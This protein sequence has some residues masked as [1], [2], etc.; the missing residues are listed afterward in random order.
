MKLAEPVPGS[1]VSPFALVHRLFE[2]GF[3]DRMAGSPGGRDPDRHWLSGKVDH[4]LIAL[5]VFS[6]QL[7]GVQPVRRLERSIKVVNGRHGRPGDVRRSMVTLWSCVGGSRVIERVP[8]AAGEAAA[9]NS[10]VPRMSSPVRS[11]DE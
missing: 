1:A 8:G 10:M 3:R 11:E 7:Y 6:T 2:Q 5:S 9:K 4:H